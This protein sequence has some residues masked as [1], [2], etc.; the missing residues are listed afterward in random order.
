MLI[1][2]NRF[3]L[4][5]SKFG[6][7][8]PGPGPLGRADSGPDNGRAEWARAHGPWPKAQLPT[9]LRIIF[10]KCHFLFELFSQTNNKFLF[11]SNIL[12]YILI[13]SPPQS[14]SIRA[15]RRSRS[16]FSKF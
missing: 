16:Q 11:N 6:P 13:I 5:L 7:P 8:G 15:I 14:G 3:L 9:M 2:N 12:P 1:T 4:N 10:Q